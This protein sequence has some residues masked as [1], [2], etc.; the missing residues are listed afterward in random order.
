MAQGDGDVDDRRATRWGVVLL[1]SPWRI[2]FAVLLVALVV[3]TVQGALRAL[4][5][6]EL[7]GLARVAVDLLWLPTL[8][9][10]GLWRLVV[11]PLHQRLAG[12][13]A[14][15]RAQEAELRDRTDLLEFDRQLRR[16]LETTEDRSDVLLV[17]ERAVGQAAPA[18]R[19]RLLLPGAVGEEVVAA[20]E[21]VGV[22][23]PGCCAASASRDCP[24]I[25]SGQPAS[26]P[27]PE[28]L[29]T[30]PMLLAADGELGASCQPVTVLGETVGV[31]TSSVAPHDL[32]DEAARTKLAGV[33]ARA[34]SRLSL[35]QALED[36]RRQATTDPLTGLVNR[37][38]LGVAHDRARAHGDRPSLLLCDLDNFKQLNDTH[39]HDAGDAALVAFADVL[40]A[41]VRPEDVPA[42]VGGEEFAVLLPDTNADE[43]ATVAERIRT[44]QTRERGARP[45]TTVS[46]GVA[47]PGAASGLEDLLRRADGALYAA[48]DAGRDTVAVAAG[49]LGGADG[50]D[51]PP[52]T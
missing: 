31:L 42:R 45:S 16:A 10:L 27:S 40:R 44:A 39:G 33:A 18:T 4:V 30:C 25:R 21:H 26:Y 36:S 52:D 38:A 47:G 29:D 46:I 11:K 20:A 19:T 48:K 17:I 24:V 2:F 7:S 51:E 37:R 3:E 23:D 41:T 5:L 14:A 8:L 34:G 43:A 1:A 50:H 13:V 35:V 12:E 32:P 15:I 49:G 28:A 9:G 22:D 6:P